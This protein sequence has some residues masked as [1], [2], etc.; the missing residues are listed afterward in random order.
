MSS[1]WGLRFAVP[2]LGFVRSKPAII[3]C[4]SPAPSDNE[5]KQQNFGMWPEWSR[6]WNNDWD[7]RHPRETSPTKPKGKTIHLIM[8]RHGQYELQNSETKGLT[9]LG[10]AQ[11][12]LTG[13]RL[14]DLSKGTISDFYGKRKVR[15]SH[16]F[17][18]NLSRASETASII[19]KHLD[20]DIQIVEDPML[21]EGWPCL[22]DPYKDP[23]SVR[24][25]KLFEESAR[26]EAVFRKYCHRHTD[27]KKERKEPMT[28]GEKEAPAVGLADANQKEDP[29]V[30]DTEEEYIVFVCHQNIIRYFVCRALQLPP[31]AWL[32]FRG[33]NC[34]IT[35]IIISDDGR[36]SLEKFA[37]VG[38]LPVTH[39]TFH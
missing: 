35:E 7:H 20:S 22:P 13:Q 30:L 26:V 18:S 14:A 10:R 38:H 4:D 2:L 28:E 8:I 1:N 32:R 15:I 33:S 24:P 25:A 23:S 16:V 17:H 12:E 37:D 9:D 34:G 3:S 6:R 31:E 39:H 36:V 27:F 11:A 19:R 5:L 21:A 29:D